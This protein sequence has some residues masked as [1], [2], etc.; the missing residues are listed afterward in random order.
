MRLRDL[1]NRSLRDIRDVPN[2]RS[3]VQENVPGR[4]NAQIANYTTADDG[5][6]LADGVPVADKK[7]SRESLSKTLKD[8]EARWTKAGVAKADEPAP[9]FGAEM[10]KL[11]LDAIRSS[12]S[13]LLKG[14][15]VARD[16]TK[17][18]LDVLRSTNAEMMQQLEDHRKSA[19][20][21]EKLVAALKQDLEVA[22][23]KMNL[24]DASA[25]S[26]MVQ[27]DQ[28]GKLADRLT[29]ELEEA[30]CNLQQGSLFAGL[31]TQL[32]E[33][34]HLV[35]SL[36]EELE[37]V[38][39]ENA[40]LKEKLHR[41][42]EVESMLA[43]T[44][45]A[46]QRQRAQNAELE[47][48]LSI[49]LQAIGLG[50]E[51]SA[52]RSGVDRDAVLVPAHTASA[53]SDVVDQTPTGHASEALAQ[54]LASVRQTSFVSFL[55]PRDVAQCAPASVALHCAARQESARCSEQPMSDMS[56]AGM[57]LETATDMCDMLP[58]TFKDFEVRL[59]KAN[60]V[61]APNIS[62]PAITSVFVETN[63]AFISCFE[64]GVASDLPALLLL[65]GLACSAHRLLT[66][67]LP[68]AEKTLLV[69]VDWRGHGRSFA[70][71]PRD[72]ETTMEDLAVDVI[73]VIRERLSK[74]S[75]N[76]R[77]RFC[78]L[79]HSMGARVLWSICGIISSDGFEKKSF[80]ELAG[81]AILDHTPNASTVGPEDL[82][83]A[84]FKQDSE[85]IRRG[86][87]EMLCTF[88]R[89]WGA[90]DR[91]FMHSQ[92]EFEEWLE[93][94]GECHPAIVSSLHINA[95]TTDYM[96]EFHSTRTKVLIVVGSATTGAS[97]ITQRF[98]AAIPPQGA[99]FAVFPGGTHCI[100]HQLEQLPEL[101]RLLR[102]LLDGSL[103]LNAFHKSKEMGGGVHLPMSYPADVFSG[104][105]IS[106]QPSSDGLHVRRR[107]RSRGPDQPM[108]GS[109]T[110]P[111]GGAVQSMGNL[112]SV[113]I[114]VVPVAPII[115]SGASDARQK[116]PFDELQERWKRMRED[117]SNRFQSAVPIRPVVP[118]T[119][120]LPARPMGQLVVVCPDPLFWHP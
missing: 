119:P 4:E 48:E 20:E 39:S 109:A 80:P 115:I 42:A 58:K 105:C 19:R 118:V 1:Q 94:A 41:H 27:L 98:Q 66:A 79:G 91:G 46:L 23:T 57:G 63:S 111:V 38:K 73:A 101:I 52:D 8:V 69:A 85:N 87:K 55:P 90:G 95:L 35:I 25:A 17:T 5:I 33:H 59:P 67:L 113:T 76:K 29:K 114:P 9:A 75:A 36:R 86:K 6:R 117:D 24:S 53:S 30:R 7:D 68:L 81:M 22:K 82:H 45:V 14:S 34:E 96:S 108:G 83:Y 120:M 18:E 78:A 3:A 37:A 2:P 61:K 100:H 110:V 15:S 16:G 74:G 93:F 40:A 92:S 89:L 50:E 84:L 104:L 28:G 112:G 70:K 107:S 64:A 65:P 43:G 97:S 99:H 71:D 106:D 32:K 13:V 102:Q 56:E 103:Q 116:T 21:H 88:K 77:G 72:T 47:Q 10:S 54:S 12:A 49:A 26:L 62:Q 44:K 11:K 31:C 51:R 60:D